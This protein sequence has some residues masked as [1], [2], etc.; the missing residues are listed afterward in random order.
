M[1][2][3]KTIGDRPN[4]KLIGNSMGQLQPSILADMTV[5]RSENATSPSPAMGWALFFNLAPESFREAGLSSRM[6]FFHL[7]RFVE[8]I[9]RTRTGLSPL[10]IAGRDHEWRTTNHTL[11][12]H[13]AN[14]STGT[15]VT[16]QVELV[17]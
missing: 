3:L 12:L 2:Q 9:T 16:L 11:N 14:N 13:C 15:S 8:R 4:F 17:S 6:S 1:I 5:S 10:S 7:F